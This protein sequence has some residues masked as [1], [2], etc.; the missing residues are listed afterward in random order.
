MLFCIVHLLTQNF[1]YLETMYSK[2]GFC[3]YNINF[4]VCTNLEHT[5][6]KHR[7]ARH[8]GCLGSHGNSDDD[9]D[10]QGQTFPGTGQT[11]TSML[12]VHKN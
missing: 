4:H 8:Q 1:F 5:E 11:P 6:Q 2:N 9:D 10:D 7:Q 12:E 3:Y